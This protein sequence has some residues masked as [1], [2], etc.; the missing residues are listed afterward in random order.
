MGGGPPTWTGPRNGIHG[1]VEF[2]ICLGVA[3]CLQEF[4]VGVRPFARLLE[5]SKVLF[6]V[7]MNVFE[8]VAA[9]A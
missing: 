7:P 4:Q 8:A 3:R 9:E 1:V 5:V 2:L 6:D